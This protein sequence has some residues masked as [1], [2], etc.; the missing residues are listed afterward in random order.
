MV[1]TLRNNELR[2]L[3]PCIAKLRNLRELNV[4]QNGLRYLPY[5]MLELLTSDCH[6]SSLNIH[7]NRFHEAYF[8]SVALNRTEED[9]QIKIGLANRSRK[10]PLQNT[11][12]SAYITKP[13]WAD[14]NT[15]WKVEFRART[16]VRYFDITG[17]LLKGPVFPSL[18]D[19]A[20]QFSTHSIP[21]VDT[22]DV[23]RPPVSHNGKLSRSPSLIEVSLNACSKTPQLPYLTEML[24]KDCPGYLHKLLADAAAKKE[25]GGSQCTICRRNFVLPRTEWIEWWEIAKNPDFGEGMALSAASPLR[26]V[27]ND[28]DVLESMVPLMRRGCSWLCVPE[29][30]VKRDLQE[31]ATS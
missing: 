22:E 10:H 29:Q 6:L 23:P 18:E 31:D 19:D 9:V 3:P 13:L 24:P 16:E 2:E 4:S 8:P 26:G 1:L 15:N 14:W 5:E 21:V 20:S 30:L 7:P 11:A 27:E 12:A 25:S 28:R 17:R